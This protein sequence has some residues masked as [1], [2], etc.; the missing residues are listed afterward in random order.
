MMGGN[1][2]EVGFIELLAKAVYDQTHT[3]GIGSSDSPISGDITDENNGGY[4]FLMVKLSPDTTGL[5]IKDT[6]LKA[7]IEGFAVLPAYPNPFN[8]S[9]T[10][11]Y[12][13]ENDSHITVEIYDISGKLVST[14]I[15]TEQTQG[16]HSVVWNGTSQIGELAPT[17]QYLSKITSGDEVKTTK[18]MLLK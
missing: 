7:I 12:G 9:T 8:P 16:W 3:V 11:S 15:N 1:E 13:L 14:L 6:Q 4:D 10:I 5:N 2:D 18:L 17:G